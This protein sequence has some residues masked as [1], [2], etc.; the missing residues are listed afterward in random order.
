MTYSEEFKLR[1]IG[2]LRASGLGY[3]EAADRFPHFPSRATL[4]KWDRELEA[5]GV[6]VE[7]PAVRITSWRSS[8][9]K[10]LPI[11]RLLFPGQ[12]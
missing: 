9:E 4:S 12:L 7:L 11:W 2:E 1:V 5:A 8:S 10:S 3:R 6:E